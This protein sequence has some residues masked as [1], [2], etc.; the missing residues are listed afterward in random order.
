MDMQTALATA[1]R[2]ERLSSTHNRIPGGSVPVSEGYGMDEIIQRREAAR[3]GSARLLDRI[4]AY[5]ARRAA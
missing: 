1:A 2:K 4:N 3:L 5:R